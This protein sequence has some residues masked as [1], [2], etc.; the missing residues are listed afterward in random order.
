MTS[1]PSGA[2]NCNCNFSL[3]YTSFNGNAW[4]RYCGWNFKGSLWNSTQNFS[5]L[6]WIITIF[7][8]SWKFTSYQIYE[9]VRVFETPRT[10]S[11]MVLSMSAWLL[12]GKTSTFCAFSVFSNDRKWKNIF[13][14]FKH[15]QEDKEHL[16]MLPPQITGIDCQCFLN[17]P[18][19]FLK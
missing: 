15:I 1:Q 3:N 14:V 4:A 17:R 7:M 5:S 16:K 8:Q 9:L 18:Y 12:R 13:Y 6:H 19:Q 11:F 2:P 10:S